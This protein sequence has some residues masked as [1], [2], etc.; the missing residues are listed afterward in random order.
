MG[1]ENGPLLRVNY[2]FGTDAE[3]PPLP[4]PP[5]PLKLLLLLFVHLIYIQ[6]LCFNIVLFYFIYV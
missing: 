6:T 5:F 2:G 4:S 3:H 1:F